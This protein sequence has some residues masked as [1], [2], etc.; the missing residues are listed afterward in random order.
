MPKH[1]TDE[2]KMSR[3]DEVIVE[4]SFVLLQ[5]SFLNI[6]FVSSII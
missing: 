4:V 5:F 3:V 2:E 1:L 6:S